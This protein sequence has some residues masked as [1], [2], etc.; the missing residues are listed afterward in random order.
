MLAVAYCCLVS[1]SQP[2]DV[3]DHF[4]PRLCFEGPLHEKFVL[5]QS[6]IPG[7]KLLQ[8]ERVLSL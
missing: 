3:M 1:A 5:E 6:F 7:R 8:N 4:S 2:F